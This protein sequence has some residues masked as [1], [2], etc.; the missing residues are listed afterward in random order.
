MMIDALLHDSAFW[1]AVSTIL[2]VGFIALKAYRPILGSLDARAA[3]IH[4]RL[5]EAEQLRREAEAVLREYKA[6][7]ENALTEA[8]QILRDAESRASLLRQKMEADLKDSIARQ[9]TSAKN[10]I[11][12]MEQDAVEGVKAAIVS[13][14]LDRARDTI[15]KQGGVGPHDLEKSVSAI[16]KSL[17]R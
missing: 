16:G 5:T 13:A 1:V 9:E 3:A 11:A 12:R 7:S 8:A 17:S 10:R 4:Q 15:V 6:K 14:S 2:C